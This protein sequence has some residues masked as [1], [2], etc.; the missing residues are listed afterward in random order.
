MNNTE[1][2]H[3]L[4]EKKLTEDEK[5]LVADKLKNDPV[6]KEEFHQLSN[7]V[8]ALKAAD[9][10]IKDMEF[11]SKSSFFSV[12]NLALAASIVLLIGI[13]FIIQFTT[14][15]KSYKEPRIAQLHDL[16]ETYKDKLSSANFKNN[17]VLECAIYQN[18]RSSDFIHNIISPLDSGVYKTNEIICFELSD[19]TKIN[20]IIILNNK[21]DTVFQKLNINQQIFEFEN[22]LEEGVYYWKYQV[23][24]K[25][26]WG[27]KFYVFSD[28]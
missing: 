24:D 28:N 9:K 22:I 25:T 23:D 5:L 26:I 6:F 19:N 15:S 2:I 12:R 17:F 10:L 8:I 20:G 27:E 4:L 13:Y 14:N 18:V 3:K 16:E 11:E 1:L 21:S 7:Q